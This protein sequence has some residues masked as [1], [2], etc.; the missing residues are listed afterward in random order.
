MSFL[1]GMTISSSAKVRRRVVRHVG[2][3]QWKRCDANDLTQDDERG[4]HKGGAA[5]GA[6][7]S[8][9]GRRLTLPSLQAV[10]H[11]RADAEGGR[12]DH[13]HQHDFSRIAERRRHPV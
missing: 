7:V 12:G 6:N 2:D 9:Q 4:P 11:E 13:D 3:P 5:D 10:Q 8:R 1:L